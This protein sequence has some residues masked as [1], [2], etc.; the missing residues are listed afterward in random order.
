MRIGIMTAGGDAP[1]L[2][3]ILEASCKA[4]L[5]QGHEVIGIEDG[6]L[7]IFEKRVKV[8]TRATV[9]G[10]HQE[11]GTLLGTS[12]KTAT[13]GREKEFIDNYKSLCL[14]ALIAAG[15]SVML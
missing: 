4:I 14:D 8:L 13:A 10:L 12:N 7:G 1:G 6:F 11:A 15:M 9:E 3:G 5:N 2:N